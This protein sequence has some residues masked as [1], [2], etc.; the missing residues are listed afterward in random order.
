MEHD[1]R[2]IAR[3]SRWSGLLSFLAGSHAKIPW[4]YFP[5]VDQLVWNLRVKLCIQLYWRPFDTKILESEAEANCK[6]ACHCATS[7]TGFQRSIT[8][9]SHRSSPKLQEK[10]DTER[11][12]VRSSSN[13]FS[14]RHQQAQALGTRSKSWALGS[15]VTFTH[16]TIDLH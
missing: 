1:G 5:L 8:I 3:A 10:C 6:G 15:L 13:D 11:Q 2:G 14:Y 12:Q 4:R 16:Q 9:M 7:D